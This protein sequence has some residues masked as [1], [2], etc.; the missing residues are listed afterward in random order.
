MVLMQVHISIHQTYS[1][2]RVTNP[3]HTHAGYISPYALKR[4]NLLQ[5]AHSQVRIL[6]I[7]GG[8]KK[9]LCKA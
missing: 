4:V 2:S 1:S 7:F 8:S 3:T 6:L 9:L 5:A